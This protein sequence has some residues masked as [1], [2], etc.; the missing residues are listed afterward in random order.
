MRIATAFV[1]CALAGIAPR[2]FADEPPQTARLTIRVVDWRNRNGQ[3][4]FSVFNQSKGFPG[5]SK[6][7][8]HWEARKLAD[9]DVIFTADLPPGK[10]AASVLHDENSNNKLDTNLIGIPTEGYGVTNNPKPKFRG[11]KYSE[12]TFELPAEG[13]SLTISLQ[14]F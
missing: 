8:V 9:G 5:D 10:Y 7:S 13:A 11:A 6:K 12:A 4:I 2:S 14:Y 3:A 1:L